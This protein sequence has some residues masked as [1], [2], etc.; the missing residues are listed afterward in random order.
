MASDSLERLLASS[1]GL[2]GAFA[3]ALP[4]RRPADVSTIAH[5]RAAERVQRV[6]SWL[7]RGSEL[8]VLTE[9]TPFLADSREDLWQYYSALPLERRLDGLLGVLLAAEVLSS[10]GILRQ[11]QFPR[12]RRVLQVYCAAV[13]VAGV[14]PK[15]LFHGLHSW[16]WA[17]ESRLALHEVGPSMPAPLSTEA[18]KA[19]SQAFESFQNVLG[20]NDGAGAPVETQWRHRWAVVLFVMS[21]G[22]TGLW[23]WDSATVKDSLESSWK[24]LK[25]W[26]SRAQ[27]LLVD[28]DLQ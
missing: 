25:H 3:L 1:S 20:I 19:L 10:S 18:G 7:L 6:A 22:A 28:R 27:L 5:V 16:L 23:W 4:E 13:G 9:R 24:R 8:T 2:L 12:T 26:L 21:V 11:D 14:A 15:H 17:Y